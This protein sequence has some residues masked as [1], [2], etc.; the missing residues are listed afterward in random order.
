KMGGIGGTVEK[1]YAAVEHVV[2]PVGREPKGD[3]QS[4]VAGELREVRVDNSALRGLI[5]PLPVR[6][7]KELILDNRAAEIIADLMAIEWL[8]GR[9]IIEARAEVLSAEEIKPAAM[10]LIAATT[11]D[12]TDRSGSSKGSRKIE[13]G[14]RK[15]DLLH[16]V[17]RD[18]ACGRAYG[19]VG[20]VYSVD[21]H[22]AGP[23]G[24]AVDGDR[25]VSHDFGRVDRPA[26]PDHNARLER[27]QVEEVASV[28]RQAGD[29]LLRHHAVNGLATGVNL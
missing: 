13:R 25:A 29:L 3:R 4:G 14:A 23:A 28:E 20:N 22:A 5:S 12:D 10:E 9:L 27:G 21:L 26:V 18:I 15:L 8:G 24:A 16:G 11:R 17:G 1:F 19:L 6:K 7:E 2:Q